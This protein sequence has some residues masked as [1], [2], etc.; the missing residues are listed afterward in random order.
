MRKTLIILLIVIQIS[1]SFGQKLYLFNVDTTKL[2]VVQVNYLAYDSSFKL[3]SNTLKNEFAIKIAG[4]PLNIG[5]FS[6][7]TE[8]KYLELASIVLTIDISGS[9]SGER[10]QIAK[11]A[12]KTFVELTPLY[13]SEIAIT[14]FDQMNY[15]N[16]DF[17]KNKDKLLEAIDKIDAFGG[18]D[19]NEA[20]INKPAGATRIIQHAEHQNKIIIFLTDGIGSG[21]T[22]RIIKEALDQDAKII[23]LTIGMPMPQILTDISKKLG[24]SSFPNIKNAEDAR[25]AYLR[26]LSGIFGI[27]PGFLRFELPFLCSNENT[28]F[29]VTLGSIT[30]TILMEYP[31]HMLRNLKMSQ[32]VLDFG[33]V[34][35][36]DTAIIEFSISAVNADMNII[37]Y[38]LKDTTGAIHYPF[39]NSVPFQLAK[40]KSSTYKILYTPRDSSFIGDRFQFKT[41]TCPTKPIF[42]YA[43]NPPLDSLNGNLK[44]VYPNGGENFGIST[45]GKTLW[46]GISPFDS[47][48]IS[49]STDAGKSYRYM[50][51]TTG[52]EMTFVVPNV[53]SS[54]CLIRVDNQIVSN[55][56]YEYSFYRGATLTKFFDNNRKIFISGSNYV[57]AFDKAS[58]LIFREKNNLK[59]VSHIALSPNAQV[60]SLTYPKEVQIYSQHTFQKLGKIAAHKIF[61][62]S[63]GKLHKERITQTAFN[64]DNQ[65]F[66]TADFSGVIKIWDIQQ[67]K[68]YAKL[69]PFKS[70]I[71]KI[72]FIKYDTTFYVAS[73][74]EIKFYS[75]KTLTEYQNSSFKNNIADIAIDAKEEFMLVAETD[76]YVS[77]IDLLTL[78]KVDEKRLSTKAKTLAID[79]KDHRFVLVAG[80]EMIF[81]TYPQFQELFSIKE[82][83]NLSTID[84]NQDGDQ[85]LTTSNRNINIWSAYKR[86]IQSDVSDSLFS[87]QG[88]LPLLLKADIGVSYPHFSIGRFMPNFVYNPN[89]YPID[90]KDIIIEGK[91]AS[92]FNLVSGIPPFQLN[93]E[94]G[95]TIEFSYISS[96]VAKDTVDV[97]FVTISDT[98]VTQIFAETVALPFD[99]LDK[100]FDFGTVPPNQSKSQR[101]QLLKNISPNVLEIENVFLMGGNDMYFQFDRT[102]CGV[103]IQSGEIFSFDATYY[104]YQIGIST[105]GLKIKF[106]NIPQ[107]LSITLIGT[108]SAP[109]IIS[110]NGKL[111]DL[112]SYKPITGSI[113]QTDYQSGKA[114]TIVNTDSAGNYS[115]K[116]SIDR[117]HYLKS[118]ATNYSSDDTLID[119]RVL[120]EDSVISHNFFLDPDYSLL[121]KVNVHIFFDT[122]KWELKIEG[123]RQLAGLIRYLNA[124]EKVKLEIIGHT[125]NL[126]TNE[127]NNNLSQQRAK[128]VNDYIV[129]QGIRSGRLNYSGKGANEPIASNHTPEGQQLNRRV[130]IKFTK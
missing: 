35:P 68:L 88:G 19:Y 85:L 118:Q 121:N 112:L 58:G 57:A 125:D 8:A 9:M 49:L 6:A 114:I 4:N 116:L 94:S 104:A 95:E 92:K 111:C 51:T 130:E 38:T 124:N 29:D 32:D 122:D 3:V 46:E 63:F 81:Y 101:I 99:L 61:N 105:L 98:L 52:S 106:K 79:P 13:A 33:T 93:P 109:K 27:T 107:L 128:T 28:N 67:G 75:L 72:G 64:F 129:S 126:G 71:N 65:Y 39:L 30:E 53:L 84:F 60:F 20:L 56:Q 11:D 80:D 36:G 5:K 119:L 41:S 66:A 34:K 37:G 108:C 102:F 22:D 96:E 24:T 70:A 69:K 42:I 115:I 2:P 76:G 26:V 110:L 25:E 87:I 15:V 127:H 45:S 21:N 23:P 54:E 100:Y 47:V 82:E 86:F 117:I 55:K 59:N 43:G 97:K 74:K 83:K 31:A 14:T 62:Y 48:A 78:H 73:N 12:A 50:G 1:Q 123:K 113:E 89:N 103:R 90:I 17:T 40:G 44:V 120:Q 10:I 77:A 7:P 91:K 16:Q 18:T